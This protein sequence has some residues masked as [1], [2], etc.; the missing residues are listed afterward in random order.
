M[1]VAELLLMSSS[2][3]NDLPSRM[4]SSV[5]LDVTPSRIFSSAAVEVTATPPRL[6]VLDTDNVVKE[7]AAGVAPPITAASI[8]PPLISTVVTAPRSDTVAPFKLTVPV[9][10]RLAN[11]AVP[12]NV[13][14]ARSDLVAIAVETALN[15][16]SNSE[17]RTTLLASPVGNESLA[18]KFVDFV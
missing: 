3:T 1:A 10:V 9:A 14:L 2:S 18:V 16:V 11:V 5:A 8:V 17:P 7:P 12:V 15:S 6:K 4:L 13:G